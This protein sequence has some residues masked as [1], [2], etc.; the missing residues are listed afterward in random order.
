MIRKN[1]KQ[2]FL[3]CPCEVTYTNTKNTASVVT[4]MSQQ[5]VLEPVISS[6]NYH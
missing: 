1:D 4:H 5:S 3:R 2:E 6:Y